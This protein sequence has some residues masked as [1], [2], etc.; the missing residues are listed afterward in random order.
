MQRWRLHQTWVNYILTNY[1]WI[2]IKQLNNILAITITITTNY[3]KALHRRHQRCTETEVVITSFKEKT[4][5]MQA[6]MSRGRL[7]QCGQ[8][9]EWS[10]TLIPSGLP[11]RILDMY[12]TKW[13]LAFVCFSFF[14]FAARC[15]LVQIAVL[16]SH[17]VSLC[18]S[19]TLV[20][21]DHI[22][23]ILPK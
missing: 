8:L 18:P 23:W 11:S 4:T 2:T 7:C 22:G 16:R 20:D 13:A 10:V 6:V 14:F 1:N 15:T 12:W 19:V 5:D 21:C 3:C 17:V 9:I